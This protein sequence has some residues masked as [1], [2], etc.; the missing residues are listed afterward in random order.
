MLIRYLSLL[1]WR[2]LAGD[3]SCVF[4]AH[5]ESKSFVLL[6]LCGTHDL[7]LQCCEW[8]SKSM[9]ILNGPP[10]Q[11]FCTVCCLKLC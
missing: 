11:N 2:Y 9:S 3:G 10:K 1:K 7:C 6:F 5:S 8:H 4:D